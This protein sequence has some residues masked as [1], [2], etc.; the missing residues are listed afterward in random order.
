MTNKNETQTHLPG[1]WC[2]SMPMCEKCADDAGYVAWLNSLDR[3]K[4]EWREW[5]RLFGDLE[6]VRWA[7]TAALPLGL[8]AEAWRRHQQCW[9]EDEFM[10]FLRAEVMVRHRLLDADPS[11]RAVMEELTRALYR[12][13]IAVLARY[14]DLDRLTPEVR[15]QAMG[16]TAEA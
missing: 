13:E 11:A 9:R 14:A 2:T 8:D 16:I 7:L 4:N 1:E 15:A 10:E 6:G 3:P 12:S 5:H